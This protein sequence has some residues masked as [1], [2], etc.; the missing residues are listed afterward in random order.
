MTVVTNNRVK[1]TATGTASGVDFT[2]STKVDSF[3]DFPTSGTFK[4]TALADDG[5]WQV[6]EGVVTG[7]TLTR[8]TVEENH[9]Y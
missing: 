5:T 1:V 4:Y 3:S 6:G 2:L 9:E 8:G 7:T